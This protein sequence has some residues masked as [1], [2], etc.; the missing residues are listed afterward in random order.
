MLDAA[1]AEN[2]QGTGEK[3]QSRQID[4]FTAGLAECSARRLPCF[5][6]LALVAVNCDDQSRSRRPTETSVWLGRH[7]EYDEH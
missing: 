5:G 3:L 6:N 4:D 2:A 7:D 1:G